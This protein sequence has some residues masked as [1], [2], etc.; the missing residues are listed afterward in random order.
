MARLSSYC[1]MR[2]IHCYFLLFFLYVLQLVLFQS[3]RDQELSYNDE[4][5]DFLL[6]INILLLA[7]VLVALLLYWIR[8]FAFERLVVLFDSLVFGLL[9]GWLI[10]T[11]AR[12]EASASFVV[13]NMVVAVSLFLVDL[14]THKQSSEKF[15]PL[16]IS[17]RGSSKR[18]D[19]NDLERS[20]LDALRL[21]SSTTKSTNSN[22]GT[23]FRRGKKFGSNVPTM[24]VEEGLPGRPISSTADSDD[25]SQLVVSVPIRSAASVPANSELHFLVRTRPSSGLSATSSDGASPRESLVENELVPTPIVK[26]LYNRLEHGV[27]EGFR[28]HLEKLPVLGEALRGTEHE[29]IVEDIPRDLDWKAFDEVKH[30]VDSSSCQIYTAWWRN[31]GIPVVLKII[32]GERMTPVA[33]AEFE[34][35]EN[36]LSRVRHPHIIRLLGAGR[37]PR[38][39]L[40]LELLSGGTLAHTLGLRFD[41]PERV[42]GK[43]TFRGNGERGSESYDPSSVP[44]SGLWKK[45]FTL[46]ESLHIAYSLAQA[47]NYLHSEW[48]PCIHL[49]HRDLKPDNIGWS[50]DGSLKLFDFGLCASVRAQRERTEQY[51]LTGNTGTLRYMAPE[52][53]LGRSY[54]KSV[55]TYSF[56]IIVWQIVTGKLPFSEMG[57]KTFF[58]EVVIGGVRP[59]LFARWPIEFN[60]LLQRCWHEDK[61]K[62]PSFGTIVH[63]LE[64]LIERVEVSTRERSERLDVKFLRLCAHFAML[65]RPLL[66]CVLLVV[67]LCVIFLAEQEEMDINVSGAIGGLAAFGAY[68][69]AMS[70]LRL[71][72]YIHLPKG[73]LPHYDSSLLDSARIEG[74]ISKSA[75][76]SSKRSSKPMDASTTTG[77]HGR[78]S[79]VGLFSRSASSMG[80]LEAEYEMTETHS[81][82]MFPGNSSQTRRRIDQGNLPTDSGEESLTS[83][84]YSSGSDHHTATDSE[85][86]LGLRPTERVHLPATYN[87]INKQS[88]EILQRENS[89]RYY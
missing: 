43:P 70:L 16:S 64:L 81:F 89:S 55:D 47:L 19:R 68:S 39:F 38:K 25:S 82:G 11:S 78:F 52:V 45:R 53:V 61:N 29:E 75:A 2:R 87:P 57:K 88:S 56:G 77:K 63:E 58:D 80:D 15:N 84:N 69:T 36:V 32:K 85:R 27:C 28:V 18:D 51:R 22:N 21:S 8:P 48:S 30:R 37:S 13:I 1:C 40:V 79:N 60:S 66:F 3:S 72:P 33:I 26:N 83:S 35:E 65:V 17:I 10:L 7:V 46:L 76:Y 12:A 50:L 20:S 41:A 4:T 74:R 31:K 73:S 34:T 71:W 54:H 5:A 59:R 86:S 44:Q 23:I 9:A 62:R 67:L 14:F 6:T 49:I 42:I 24:D